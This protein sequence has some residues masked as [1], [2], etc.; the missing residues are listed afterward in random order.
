MPVTLLQWG[1]VLAMG[2]IMIAMGLYSAFFGLYAERRRARLIYGL[3]LFAYMTWIYPALLGLMSSVLF[4]HPD[5]HVLRAGAVILQGAGLVIALYVSGRHAGYVFRIICC[6]IGILVGL[7]FGLVLR[8]TLGIA[9]PIFGI[10]VPAVTAAIGGWIGWEKGPTVRAGWK[11]VCFAAAGAGMTASGSVAIIVAWL[12]DEPLRQT[13]DLIL[14]ILSPPLKL[15]ISDFS[16]AEML[17]S[18]AVTAI[19]FVV[20]AAI[21]CGQLRRSAPNEAAVCDLI[22]ARLAR[23]GK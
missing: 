15:L 6:S 23:I 12:K 5:P 11:I 13:F 10:V 9:S 22:I 21:Q 18:A 19:V 16:I 14:S 8:T 17:A 4:M 20:G 7:A 2:S 3:T 1:P